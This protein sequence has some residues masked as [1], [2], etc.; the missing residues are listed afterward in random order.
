M[1]VDKAEG[2]VRDFRQYAGRV[3]ERRLQQ[4]QQDGGGGKERATDHV[5]SVRGHSVAAQG[6]AGLQLLLSRRTAGRARKAA[7]GGARR[8]VCLRLLGE[9]GA[10]ATSRTDKAGPNSGEFSYDCR[11]EFWRIQL[12]GG[13]FFGGGEDRVG[14]DA[15]VFVDFLVR[16]R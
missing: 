14:S 12:L 15:A 10:M 1:D 3:C 7:R 8:Q 5:V 2:V 11:A 4:K 9:A 6:M 16:G 13:E